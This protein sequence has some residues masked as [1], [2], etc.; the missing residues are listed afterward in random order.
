MST[1]VFL[2][3]EYL[4]FPADEG[5]KNIAYNLINRLRQTVDLQIVSKDGHC[6]NILDVEKLNLNKL[7][8]NNRLRFL[9]K[10]YTSEI[11]LYIPE[12]SCTFN[13]FIRAKILKLMSKKAKVVMLACQHK[14]FLFFHKPLLNFLRS[15]LLF[16]L[17][18]SDKDFFESKGM[19][20]KILPPAIDKKKFHKV[21]TEKKMALRKKYHIPCDKTIIT[22]VGHIKMNRNIECFITIQCINTLQA[23]IVG[24]ITD[25]ADMNLRKR[26][27]NNGIIV[28]NDYLPDIQE[29]YQLSDIYV[30]PVLK[31]DAAIEMPLSVLEAMACNLPI[32]TTRFSGLV[33]H[34]KEDVGFKYFERIEELSKSIKDIETVEIHNDQKVEGFTWDKFAYEILSACEELP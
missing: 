8:L 10:N 19:R 6:T 5:L 9:L 17:G 33:D 16:L 15:D 7:F 11:I 30:F 28:I 24:S 31:R 34:F 20:V 23:V 4:S 22:H 26:L 3:S 27:E 12:A 25:K 18:K 2:I 21:K 1:K 13:S 29:I 32:I 14:R